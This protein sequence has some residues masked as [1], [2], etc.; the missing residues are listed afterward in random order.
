[1]ISSSQSKC[2]C[3]THMFHWETTCTSNNEFLHK[4][5][6]YDRNNRC[7]ATVQKDQQWSSFVQLVVSSLFYAEEQGITQTTANEMPVVNMF[8][9][10]FKRMFRDAIFAVGNYGEMY[11][12]SMEEDF[13]RSATPNMLNSDSDPQLAAMP[14]LWGTPAIAN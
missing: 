3:P 12:R 2:V 14:G 5:L 7:V 8:G 4:L 11:D 1:M 6:A 10:T 9:N 13:S